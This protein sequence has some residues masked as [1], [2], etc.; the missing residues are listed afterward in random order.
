VPGPGQ[1]L[2]RVLAAPAN[3][4]DVHARVEAT[5]APSAP[6]VL[7]DAAAA[8]LYIAHPSARIGLRRRERLAAVQLGKAAGARVIDELAKLAATGLIRPLVTE[9][10][11]MDGVPDGLRRLAAGF[12]MGKIVFIP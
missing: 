11:T 3:F 6:A 12:T 8:S 4:P 2:V 9:R 10:L 7:N 5:A 1:L